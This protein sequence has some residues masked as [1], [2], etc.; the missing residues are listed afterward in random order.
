MVANASKQ[1]RNAKPKHSLVNGLKLKETTTIPT[2]HHAGASDEARTF[3]FGWH[4]CLARRTADS[5]QSSSLVIWSWKAGIPSFGGPSCLGG[6]EEKHC[7]VLRSL[8]TRSFP[9]QLLY[10][11]Y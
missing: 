5:S 6:G 11:V 4:C 7:G 8:S 2:T 9:I 1:G 3:N 10:I